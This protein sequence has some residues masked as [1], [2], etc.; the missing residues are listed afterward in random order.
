MLKFLFVVEYN[1]FRKSKSDG[2]LEFLAKTIN[3]YDII[4]IQEVVMEN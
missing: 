3:N 2:E 1:E 4:T